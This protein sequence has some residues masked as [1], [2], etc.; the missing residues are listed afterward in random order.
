MTLEIIAMPL[1]LKK[2]FLLARNPFCSI[3]TDFVFDG[4]MSQGT[5]CSHW[6]TPV[7]L[8]LAR[9]Q[10]CHHTLQRRELMWKLG[11]KTV[12]RGSRKHSCC[13][14]K[15]TAMSWSRFRSRWTPHPHNHPYNFLLCRS[16]RKG[17]LYHVLEPEWHLSLL[18]FPP[19]HVYHLFWHV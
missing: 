7:N 2:K 10:V 14:P 6:L 19:Q 18:S 16:P 13:F 11:R 9:K 1:R 4:E 3:G 17:I 15:R 5:C 8:S 12:R